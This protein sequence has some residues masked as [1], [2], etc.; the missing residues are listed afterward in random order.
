[1]ADY[2]DLCFYGGKVQDFKFISHESVIRLRHVV[3]IGRSEH[4]YVHIVYKIP[5]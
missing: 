3:R 2:I 4:V 5:R 1:M